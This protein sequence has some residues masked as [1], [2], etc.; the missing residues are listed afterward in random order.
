MP[1]DKPRDALSD[2]SKSKINSSNEVVIKP[3]SP[4]DIV[5]WVIALALLIGSGFVGE[6]L[7]AYWAPASNVW[8]RVGV[9]VACIVIA[10]GLLYATHQ[11]KSFVR[12][13]KDARL[14]LRRV[15]WP[16]KQETITTSW[17]VLIVVII[18]SI[19][20]WC[21]DHALGWIMKMI[22]G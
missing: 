8:I 18:T 14:E 7:P 21:F 3:S 10:L 2:T 19:V 15:T 20:L 5:L 17:H 22:I 13:V 11:G 1:N 9:I 4:L 16:T 12:L 6:Y